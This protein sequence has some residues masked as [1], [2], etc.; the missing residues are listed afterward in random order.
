ME[1]LMPSGRKAGFKLSEETKEKIRQSRL[2][3]PSGMLGKTQSEETKAKQR[4]ANVGK[5]NFKHTPEAIEKIRQAGKEHLADP[6]IAAKAV[7]NYKKAV[8]KRWEENPIETSRQG[9]RYKVFREVVLK[10]D[11]YTCQECG[12]TEGFMHVHHIK[13]WEEYPGLR[14]DVDNG[15]TRCNSCHAKIERGLKWTRHKAS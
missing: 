13:G 9:K 8:R 12:K 1:S 5:H 6:V 10:R 14:L 4:A 15:T 11:N 2:G 3:K 7:E